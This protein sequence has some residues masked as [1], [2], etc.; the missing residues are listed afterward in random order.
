[1]D[2]IAIAQGNDVEKF[3]GNKRRSEGDLFGVRAIEAGYFGG[4]SQSRPSSPAVSYKLSP[5]TALVD[6][7]PTAE[8][9]RSS[10]S[11][12]SSGASSLATSQH[13]KKKPSPLRLTPFDEDAVH[14]P[15]LTFGGAG[16]AYMSPVPSPRSGKGKG[17]ENLSWVSPLDVHFSRPST[18]GAAEKPRPKSYLPR[19]KFPGEIAQNGLLIATPTG[20]AAAPNSE[21]ASIFSGGISPQ[22]VEAPHVRTP[23]FSV[24]PHSATSPGL[25]QRQPSI[26]PTNGETDRPST[27]RSNRSYTNVPAPPIPTSPSYYPPKSPGS[28]GPSGSGIRSS[29]ASKP[30]VSA[31]HPK[32][33]GPQSPGDS[34]T[35]DRAHSGAASSTYSNRPSIDNE[36]MF[37]KSERRRRSC[38]S[39]AVS[40]ERSHS[41]SSMRSRSSHSLKGTRGKTMQSDLGRS[42]EQSHSQ[43]KRRASLESNALDFD[44]PLDSPFSNANAISAPITGSS[45]R[46]TSSTS[47]AVERVAIELNL[48]KGEHLSAMPAARDRSASEVSQGSVGDFYDAYYRQS[49]IAASPANQGSNAAGRH[50]RTFNVGGGASRGPRLP[51]PLKLDEGA[52][53]REPIVEMPSPGLS[54]RSSKRGENYSRMI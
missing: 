14:S 5:T 26:V 9:H 42:R 53:A 24:F 30:S 50:S 1:M 17:P 27:G 39:E 32:S 35:R 19:L 38:S 23:T 6:W 43:R 54:P 37:K 45:S 16:G 34:Q 33:A 2:D 31:Y 20:S 11:N 13:K 28:A 36:D 29:T 40:R 51:A 44:Q 21:S 22:V 10:S 8:S 52:L 3:V 18:S 15:A 48:M 49:I 12:S 7:S 25:R 4:V 41:S 47:P 46:S